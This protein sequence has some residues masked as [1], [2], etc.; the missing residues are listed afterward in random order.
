M[1]IQLAYKVLAHAWQVGKCLPQEV[2]HKQNY[3]K[4]FSTL[5]LY[6]HLYVR[7]F[8]VVANTIVI[9]VGL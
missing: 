5:T 9:V 3:G 8:I 4:S 7:S 1:N 6:V 2:C